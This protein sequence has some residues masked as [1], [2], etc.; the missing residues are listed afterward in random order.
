MLDVCLKKHVIRYMLFE[1]FE[2][3]FSNALSFYFDGMEL[4]FLKIFKL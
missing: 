4:D 1:L 3:Q 2:R